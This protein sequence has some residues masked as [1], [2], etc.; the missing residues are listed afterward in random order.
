MEMKK[1]VTTDPN[2]PA[3]GLLYQDFELYFCILTVKHQQCLELP[4]LFM[5]CYLLF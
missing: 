1:N 3:S 5:L 4:C 2:P